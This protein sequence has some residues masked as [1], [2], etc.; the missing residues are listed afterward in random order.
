MTDEAPTAQS[1]AWQSGEDLLVLFT[2]GISG[3][4]ERQRSTA[5]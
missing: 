2:D 3:R 4:Q 5:G 1:V